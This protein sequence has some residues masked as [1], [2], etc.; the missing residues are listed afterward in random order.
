[1]TVAEGIVYAYQLKPDGS[2]RRLTWEKVAQWQPDQGL[3]WLHLDCANPDALNWLQGQSGLHPLTLESL[4][5][6]GT[7]PR[8]AL[9]EDGLLIIL[10]GINSNPGQDP[11][12]MVA[13]RMFF[14]ERRIIT[15]RR[16]RVMALQDIHETIEAGNGPTR[17]GEFL[18]RIAER[19][20]DRM[21]DVIA[22]N[23]DKI[24][25]LEDAVVAGDS[26]AV[27]PQIAE[28]RRQ[29]INLR[30]Y[31]APQRD[32][33]ARL[34]H[35]RIPWLDETDRLQLREIGER[36]ARFVED[37]DTARERA[38]IS[39]EELNNKVSEQMNKA[40]YTLSIVA[41]IFLPLGLL[42]GLLG[43]NVGGIPGTESKWAFT[44]VT[45]G[46]LTVACGLIW[47]FRKIRWL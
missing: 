3:L 17:S 36:T 43:I 45:V 42:T 22:E 13:L 31:I 35:D 11:D 20:A 40:M 44:L 2:G 41:A 28:L 15:L 18:V 30:R 34:L 27:R 25:E 32:M 12:D 1:M 26:Y 19:I 5:D 4:L 29:S 37:I 23:D 21:G 24:D 47:W 7:R 46:L 16:R 9:S 33:L 39:Q 38:A 6:E 14:T 8:H 10:R